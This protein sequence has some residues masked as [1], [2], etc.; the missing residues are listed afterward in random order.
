MWSV[1]MVTH[2]RRPFMPRCPER[3]AK[4]SLGGKDCGRARW[5]CPLQHFNAGRRVSRW[6]LVRSTD[7]SETARKG[8][9]ILR[10]RGAPLDIIQYHSSMVSHSRGIRGMPGQAT[11]HARVTCPSSAFSGNMA[12]FRLAGDACTSSHASPATADDHSPWDALL[13]RRTSVGHTGRLFSAE[14][15][16]CNAHLSENIMPCYRV[17]RGIAKVSLGFILMYS[18]LA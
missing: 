10:W 6:R 16:P 7:R 12:A 2:W 13:Q 8:Q 14:F 11:L 5:P 17:I 9:V 15:W 1:E 18:H 4:T 3:L